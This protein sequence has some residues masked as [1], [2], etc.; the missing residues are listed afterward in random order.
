MY[1]SSIFYNRLPLKKKKRAYSNSSSGKEI[2]INTIY[3][4]IIFT[5]I[6]IFNISKKLLHFF[7]ISLNLI[8]FHILNFIFYFFFSS[9]QN[10]FI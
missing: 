6:E 4:I 7:L 2:R 10:V 5:P 3:M 9:Q 1:L 8:L